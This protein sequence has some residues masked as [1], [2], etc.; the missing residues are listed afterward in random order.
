MRRLKPTTE[1]LRR[2]RVVKRQAWRRSVARRAIAIETAGGPEV[3]LLPAH[4]GAES[5]L[6]SGAAETTTPLC[7]SPAPE[8]ASPT[9]PKAAPGPK[10]TLLSLLEST[11]LLAEDA[12]ALQKPEP[13]GFVIAQIRT[14]IRYC[15]LLRGGATS[16]TDG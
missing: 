15:A 12:A 16:K 3:Q 1:P 2:A 13:N 9:M 8:K 4:I 11:L 10:E 5:G 7:S 6:T 14:A